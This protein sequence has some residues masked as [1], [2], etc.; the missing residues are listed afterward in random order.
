MTESEVIAFIRI[1]LGG[2]DETTLPDE[3]ILLFYNRWVIYF[4]LANNP[5]KLPYVLYNTVVSCLQWLIT[6][7]TAS[8]NTYASRT[9]KIGDEQISVSGGVSQVQAWK[10]LLD[11]ILTNPDYVDPSMS[12]GLE[13]LIIIGGVRWD[14]YCEVKSDPNSRGPYSEQGVV[15]YT[16]QEVSEYNSLVYSDWPRRVR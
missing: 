8:G 5:D 3:V 15:P 10:D 9:E 4:D 11:Y 2:V 16:E 6:K 7:A 12:N 13:N 1:I 14:R